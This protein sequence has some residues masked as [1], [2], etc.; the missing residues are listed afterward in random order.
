MSLPQLTSL[1]LIY[2]G[3]VKRVW[4][5]AQTSDNHLWFEFTDDY[6]VFDWGKMPD[7]IE[8]K[9]KAL[10]IMGAYLFNVLA[11]NDIWQKTFKNPHPSLKIDKSWLNEFAKN[12]IVK[13]LQTNGLSHHFTRIVSQ[14]D[15]TLADVEATN[16]KDPIYLEVLKA[17]V[18]RPQIEEVFGQKIF[19]Y[20]QINTDIKQRLIPLEVVFR[21]GMPEGSSLKNRLAKDPNYYKQIGLSRCP[22]ENEWFGQPTIEFFTKLEPKDRLLGLQEAIL[23]S[24]LTNDQFQTLIA[25]SQSIAICLGNIFAHANI[26]LWDGKFEFILNNDQILLAD[27]IGPD[28]LRLI[29]KNCHLSKETI[30]KY[31]RKTQWY[32]S[33]LKAQEMAV[34]DNSLDWKDICVNRL[35]EKP[36]SLPHNFKQAINYLY[37]SLTNHLVGKKLFPNQLELNKLAE[38]LTNAFT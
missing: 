25:L 32:Q 24:Q 29:Y 34:N 5:K 35:K 27:S 28:E 10:A 13:E 26:E 4:Q 30:R 18:I 33:M 21:F 15:K 17:N 16:C 12:D 1:N 7:Q 22:K 36:E 31:Y 2:E 14:N 3:S 8:N 37:G 6:S 9:G 20:P 38:E 19:Y 11:K 23:I